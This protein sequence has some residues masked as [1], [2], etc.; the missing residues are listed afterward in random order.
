MD[1]VLDVDPGRLER[2]IEQER[3]GWNR[4]QIIE[5]AGHALERLRA[6]ADKPKK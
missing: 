3:D 1:A 5:S 4:E 2:I 6:I